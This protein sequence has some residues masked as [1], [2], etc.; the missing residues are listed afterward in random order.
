MRLQKNLSNLLK[1]LPSGENFKHMARKLRD[2]FLGLVTPGFLF[3][4][5]GF[6]YVGPIDGHNISE[7]IATLE[8]QVGR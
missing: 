3:E 2:F 5:L 8:S 1:S 6:Q 4:S 7:M